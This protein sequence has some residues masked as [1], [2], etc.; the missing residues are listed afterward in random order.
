MN[1]HVYVD[2]LTPL[3]C[4]TLLRSHH[5]GR[6][7]FVDSAGLPTILPVNYCVNDD[8]VM[9]RTDTGEIFDGV[10]NHN[11]AFEV[12]GHDSDMRT[13]WSV[14][15]RG[16][17]HEVTGAEDILYEMH[18]SDMPPT[19]V[20]GPRRRLLAI[21]PTSISGRQIVRIWS[22]DPVTSPA[23]SLVDDVL[24]FPSHSV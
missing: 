2:Q 8:E 15:V 24:R 13:G 1:Q 20:P 17:A 4:R 11:V 21:R 14:L 3:V 10:P 5:L 19:W 22:D 9:F 6:I 23:P 12:D 7:A 16:S 18:A